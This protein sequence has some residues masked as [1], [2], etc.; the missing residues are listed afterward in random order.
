MW[1]QWVQLYYKRY[2]TWGDQPKQASWVVQKIIKAKKHFEKAGYSEEEVLQMDKFSIKAMYSK[3]RGDFTKVSWRRMTCNNAG[4]PKWTFTLYLA[5]HRRLLTRERL[6]RWG[7]LE[8]TSCAPC[9]SEEETIDHLFFKCSFSAQVWAAM[10]EWQGIKRQVMA[11]GQELEWA[12]RQYKGKSRTAEVY[13]M[14]LAGSIY[15]IWQE[16]NAQIFQA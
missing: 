5:G 12:E 10:L 8:D 15:Y 4:L 11:W 1:I 9:N 16:R 3:L 14:V 13:R 6:G 2:I 7:F